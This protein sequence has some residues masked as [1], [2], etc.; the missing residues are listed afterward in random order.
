MEKIDGRQDG[1]NPTAN[2][3]IQAALSVI[4]QQ[5]ISN[6]EQ[7][8]K[9]LCVFEPHTERPHNNHLNSLPTSFAERP[10]MPDCKFFLKTGQCKYGMGC[11]Y[12]HVREM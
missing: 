11:K 12:N 6:L 3:D 1:E 5:E 9:S 7:Q 10:H 4:E 8:I 2:S